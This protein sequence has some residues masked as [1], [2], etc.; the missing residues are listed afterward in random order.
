MDFFYLINY[1]LSF[2]LILYA[3]SNLPRKIVDTVIH[4]FDHFIREIYLPSLEND[5]KAILRKEQI[6]NTVLLE[7]ER[8]FRDYNSIFQ[9]VYTE[10]KQFD[11]LR[12]KG[13][14]DFEEF[15]IGR[16]FVEK[17]KGNG[18]SFVL[19]N[20]YAIHIPL[21]KSLKLCLRIPGIFN[22]ISN[23]VTKLATQTY[24]ITNIIQCNVLKK[25]FSKGRRT[26]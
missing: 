6:S 17:V 3:D 21:R 20:I 5:L 11:L 2:I 19:K 10:P 23:Y 22:Q 7:I 14:F 24:T 8:C 25:Y 26:I 13:L 4:F 12:R 1:I 15:M 9:H 16:H 18:F